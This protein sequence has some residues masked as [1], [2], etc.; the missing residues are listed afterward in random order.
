MRYG[1][2]LAAQRT[3]AQDF[4]RQAYEYGNR[5]L[6]AHQI[7]DLGDWAKVSDVWGKFGSSKIVVHST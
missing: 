7:E 6:V 1:G 3:K 4:A 2:E 5:P